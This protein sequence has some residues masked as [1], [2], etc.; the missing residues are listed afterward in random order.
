MSLILD[1]L[2]KREREKQ[3][4][5]RG[6]LVTAR[7]PWPARRGPRLLAG[8]VAVAVAVGAV[9]FWI[10]GTARAP[11]RIASPAP[12]SSDAPWAAVPQPEPEPTTTAVA[13]PLS[14][15]EPV[16]RPPAPRQRTP[17]QGDDAPRDSGQPL[18]EPTASGLPG[19]EEFV[20]HAISRRDGQPVALLNDRVVREGDRF[21]DVRILRIGET[22]IEIEVRGDRRVLRF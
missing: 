13:D 21:G 11:A 2:K 14:S 20:L 9:A 10:T 5:E 18:P 6:F 15:S 1:A 17:P 4:P 3:V 19:D 16:A 7:A 8:V 12:P 22:E